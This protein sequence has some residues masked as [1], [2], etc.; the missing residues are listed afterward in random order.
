MSRS[1]LMS[2]EP[3]FKNYIATAVSQSPV[4]HR[5]PCCH[6]QS[7]QIPLF[8]AEISGWLAGY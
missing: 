8:L 6:M 7:N 4:G 2:V 3:I 5:D 1:V